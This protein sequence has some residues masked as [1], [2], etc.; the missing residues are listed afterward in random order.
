MS[1][2]LPS[3]NENYKTLKDIA[4]TIRN[5]GNKEI[6]DI[7]NLLPMVEKATAAYKACK[8]RLDAVKLALAELEVDSQGDK[9][10]N[11]LEQGTVEDGEIP[12]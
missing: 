2:N 5:E 11:S 1:S 6:P 3:F 7:D 9:A 4:E 10:E 8:Q 12:F